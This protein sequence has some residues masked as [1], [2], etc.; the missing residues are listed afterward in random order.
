MHTGFQSQCIRL[1][2]PALFKNMNIIIS[3]ADI[4]PAKK[5]YFVDSVKD[6]SDD[7]FIT[8]R[9]AYI[10]QKMYGICYNLANSKTWS[11][12]FS[13]ND[14]NDIRCTLQKWYTP[15]YNGKKNCAGWFT[16]QEMMFKYLQ[17]WSNKDNHVI[18]KDNDLK[19]NRLDK[20]HRNFISSIH[21]DL[22][23]NIENKIYTDF[24]FIRPY[25]KFKNKLLKITNMIN[26]SNKN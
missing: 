22:I 9:D 17:N 2:Y 13:I 26:K 23:Y 25:N 14:E 21:K 11:E 1:L 6:Y 20:R 24:H 16:D 5:E 10:P 15:L 12:L 4:V 8:Y 3:D 18:L 7:K 19:F